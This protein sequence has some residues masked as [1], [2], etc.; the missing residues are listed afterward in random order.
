MERP[1]GFVDSNSSLCCIKV[2]GTDKVFVQ[3]FLFRCIDFCIKM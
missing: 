2:G 1:Y 3:Y